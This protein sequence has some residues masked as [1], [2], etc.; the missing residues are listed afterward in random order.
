KSVNA[1]LAQA[2]GEIAARDHIKL[3]LDLVPD[4]RL[5]P[6][7]VDAL[8][9]IACEAV[10]NAARHSGASRVNLSLQHQ[11]RS[12]RLRVSDDGSGFDTVAQADGFGLG[13][14]RDR[15]LSVGGDLRISSVPGR[16]TEV[17]V[18]L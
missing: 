15:A 9:R 17:E 12:V 4:I 6:A 5:S 14:M 18:K 3:E 16:G 10:S 8:V 13:S 7:R 2:V 1:A 11:G